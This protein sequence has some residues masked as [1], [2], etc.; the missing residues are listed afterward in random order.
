MNFSLPPELLSLRYRVASSNYTLEPF[1]RLSPTHRDLLGSFQQDAGFYGILQPLRPG[2]GYRTADQETAGLLHALK[3]PDHL[4]SSARGGDPSD[5]LRLVLDGV[6]EIEWDGV[7]LTGPKAHG[8]I[9][10]RSTDPVASGAAGLSLAALQ[11]AESLEDPDPLSLAERLYAFNRLPAS[12]QWRRALPSAE[13]VA[14][15][16]RLEPGEAFSS[17]LEHGGFTPS[18]STGWLSWQRSSSNGYP[19]RKLYLSPL[20]R[21]L[22]QVLE[23]LPEMV[24]G[25]DGVDS[26]KVGDGIEGI[27]RPDKCVVYLTDHAS[28]LRLADRLRSEFPGVPGHGVPFTALLTSDGLMS[29]GSDPVE[30]AGWRG[31][32]GGESWRSWVVK[33]LAAALVMA[34]AAGYHDGAPIRFAIDRVALEGVDPVSWSPADSFSG[35]AAH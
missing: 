19:V 22:P 4:P 18:A 23:L 26:L 5:L 16:L 33:R 2:L 12:P 15:F 6:L 31:W 21:Y 29:W 8:A 11:Y 1:D 17:A 30:T 9:F 24:A 32:T 28:L 7:F 3:K 10:P 25:I 35:Y 13:A 27:L 34:Q 14:R 20:P